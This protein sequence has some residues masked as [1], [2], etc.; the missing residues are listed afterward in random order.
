MLLTM[1]H[2]EGDMVWMLGCAAVVI[3]QPVHHTFIVPSA[4]VQS[5]LYKVFNFIITLLCSTTQN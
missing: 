2:V 1:L 4:V 5:L 3:G